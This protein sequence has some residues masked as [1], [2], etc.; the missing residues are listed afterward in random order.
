MAEITVG[1]KTVVVRD[2]LP[3][4]ENNELHYQLLRLDENSTWEERA[5]AL[6][7]CVESWGFDGDPT[8]VDA[9]GDLDVFESLAIEREV[10]SGKA[11]VTIRE[12][13]PQRVYGG[14][15]KAIGRIAQENMPWKKRVSILMDFVESWEHEGDV[16]DVDAWGDLSVSVIL[17]IEVEALT[18]LQAKAIASKN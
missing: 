12:R 6:S 17:A 3:L 7:Q 15:R 2:D 13:F 14:L 4:R 1:G 5:R 11:Q 18:L 9:W 8:Q 10:T 16:E